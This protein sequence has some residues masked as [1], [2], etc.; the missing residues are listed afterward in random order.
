MPER[1][2]GASSKRGWIYG[3]CICCHRY[4]TPDQAALLDQ[5]VVRQ[6][7][8]VMVDRVLTCE[9]FTTGHVTTVAATPSTTVHQ[10]GTRLEASE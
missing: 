4:V 3:A 7:V 6:F 2:T 10:V 5:M 1:C 9:G 8:P